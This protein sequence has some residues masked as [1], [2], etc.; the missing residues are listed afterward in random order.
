[1]VGFG[2]AGWKN[3]GAVLLLLEG[4]VA[5]G[6]N[7]TPFGAKLPFTEA[8]PKISVKKNELDKVFFKK[9]KKGLINSTK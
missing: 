9:E 8:L 6:F 7:A 2:F 1:M 5:Q 3:D 4:G